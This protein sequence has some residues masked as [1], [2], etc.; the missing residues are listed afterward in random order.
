[1]IAAHSE[2]T[3]VDREALLKRAADQLNRLMPYRKNAENRS[4][5]DQSAEIDLMD[6]LE[7]WRLGI[8]DQNHVDGAKGDAEAK[9][10][11]W[12]MLELFPEQTESDEA[13]KRAGDEEVITIDLLTDPKHAA[14]QDR[15]K[16]GFNAGSGTLVASIAGGILSGVAS[17]S[18]SSAGKASA[19]SSSS[20][21]EYKPSYAAPSVEHSYSVIN[22]HVKRVV[23]Y[24]PILDPI[25]IRFNCF[26]I[27]SM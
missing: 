17:A 25:R 22:I 11:P 19:G 26:Y 12:E 23:H 27:A 16:R 9:D 20:S 14:M 10:V 4:A 24:D 13:A 21:S 8:A 3:D 5:G 15:I 18:S 1:M 7:T 6:L 2:T